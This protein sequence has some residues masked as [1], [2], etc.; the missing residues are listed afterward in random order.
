VTSKAALPFRRLYWLLLPACALLLD[1]GSKRWILHR[2][3]PEES[4]SVIPGF[5][6]LTLGFNRGAIFGSFNSAP[7]WLRFTLFTLAGLAAL[8]YFGREF[9]K[10]E[11]PTVQRVALGL[12]LGGALGNGLDRI[13]Y[14]AVVDFLDFYARNWNLGFTHFSWHYWAFNIADSCILSGAILF[15]LALI[16]QGR[17]DQSTS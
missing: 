12:I 13:L 6:N 7:D 5:F 3:Q 14:G 9:L 1:W 16:R 4:L 8:V 17:R 10:A 15:G 2:L 11:T